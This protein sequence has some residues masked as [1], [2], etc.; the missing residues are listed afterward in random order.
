MGV[1][2]KC[3]CCPEWQRFKDR[4]EFV[5]VWVRKVVD[6]TPMGQPPFGLDGSGIFKIA[7]IGCNCIVLILFEGSPLSPS[8][9][10]VVR[11]EEIV[12]M[13]GGPL[14]T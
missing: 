5:R 8:R 10:Y 3:D 11:C 9:K 1:V 7:E 2:K 14:P 4:D 12:A 13:R 6:N